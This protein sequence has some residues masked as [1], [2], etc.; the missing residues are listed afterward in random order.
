MN[1]ELD[2]GDGLKH[3]RRDT[4]VMPQWAGSSWYQLRYIDPQNPD[5]FCA[6]ENEQYWTGPQFPGDCGGVDLYVGG[7]EHAVLHLMYARFWHKVLF[8]L[9]YVSSYEPYRR[10]Y[11]QG[12][13][14]AF[15]YTDSRGVYVPAAEVEE[16]DGKFYYQGEEVTQEYGKMGKSLKNSVS[17]DEIC[18][19]YGADTLRVYEMAM[20]P[21]DTS[22]PW[23][24][25]DVVG[26]QRFLQRLWRLVVDEETGDVTVSDTELDDDTAKALHRTIAGIRDD[27]ENLRL[28]T[29]VA[30]AIEYVNFLTKHFATTPVPRAAVT[31]IVIMIAPIAP[32]I[33]EELWQRLG[34]D[35]TITYA[36][37][38]TF[39]EKWLVDDEIELPV[40]IN[41][42]VRSRIMVPT[43]A[44]RD[45][46][47]AIA[48]ADATIQSH[49][50][51]KTVVKQI[52]VPGRMVNLVVK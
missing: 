2:L 47:A 19:D 32:H 25:K 15:A 1:V 29:V 42:K 51:D 41:G 24:T 35:D 50:A 12:Y 38:P 6:L 22:R 8:D 40:Q 34:H 23:A 48:L 7:V 30:K 3:Y 9:G 31:P 5:E 10:L 13:I 21:L 52:V 16:R 18:D 44:N 49:I 28:N 27:Y 36:N 37:F 33:A 45:Q 26:A 11:N 20:G 46:I 14:Q 4:N 43:E 39:D 17:P